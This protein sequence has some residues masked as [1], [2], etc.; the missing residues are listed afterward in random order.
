MKDNISLPVYN[1]SIN[2]IIEF[3]KKVDLFKGI[4]SFIY[5]IFEYFVYIY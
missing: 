1:S 4:K 5:S 3:E 2:E